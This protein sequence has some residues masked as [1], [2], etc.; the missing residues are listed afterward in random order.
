M[1]ALSEIKIDDDVKQQTLAPDRDH[2]LAIKAEVHNYSD[3]DQ[4]FENVTHEKLN[5][6]IVI[7]SVVEE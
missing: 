7:K 5:R 3:T 4:L 6:S 1:G 2:S